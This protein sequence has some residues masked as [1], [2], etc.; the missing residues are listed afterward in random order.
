M[1]EA[2]LQD[3][4]DENYQPRDAQK[5]L[6]KS[7]MVVIFCYTLFCSGLVIVGGICFNEFVSAAMN[8]EPEEFT[9]QLQENPDEL[10]NRGRRVPF[11]ALATLFCFGLGWLIAKLAPF[12]KMVHGVILVL[13]VAATMFVF[14]TGKD[15]P[16]EIQR[17]C[18]IMVALGPIAIVIG[19]RLGM[20]KGNQIQNTEH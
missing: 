16:A 3:D 19:T 1:S 9:K 17:V 13:L 2:D 18:M 12:S 7:F 5:L 20:G 8:L 11:A 4:Y 14:A 10:L 6:M 15:T